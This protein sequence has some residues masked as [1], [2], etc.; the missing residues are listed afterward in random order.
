MIQLSPD[1]IIYVNPKNRPTVLFERGATDIDYWYHWKKRKL[2][3]LDYE[4]V[5]E[6]NVLVGPI[7]RVLTRIGWNHKYWQNLLL[8]RGRIEVVFMGPGYTPFVRENTKYNALIFRNYINTH[9]SILRDDNYLCC[10]GGPP[11]YYKSAGKKK[12]FPDIIK[13]YGGWPKLG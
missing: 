4:P 10:A 2:R 8:T 5:R 1:P 11:P 12:H 3:K 13:Y 7:T 9:R 6:E